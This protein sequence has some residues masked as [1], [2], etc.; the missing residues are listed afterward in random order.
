MQNELSIFN[1]QNID[2]LPMTTRWAI[3]KQ[4]GEQIKEVMLNKIREDGRA[5]LANTALE[6]VGTLSSLEQHLSQVTPHASE[7]YKHLVD[8][9]T[10]GAAN[11]IARY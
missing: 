8:A 5:Y 6:H 3:Q 11:R 1:S 7:R 2:N 4:G 9:Y 10:M